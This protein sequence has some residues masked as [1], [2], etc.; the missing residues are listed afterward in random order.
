MLS[1]NHV[2]LFEGRDD[3]LSGHILQSK[4][5]KANE[6]LHRI[7]TT[8]VIPAMYNHVYETYATSHDMMLM[9]LD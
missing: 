2:C 1:A 4:A 8:Y 9:R 6:I 7:D 5:V 3:I